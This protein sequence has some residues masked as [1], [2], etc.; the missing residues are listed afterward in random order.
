MENSSQKEPWEVAVEEAIAAGETIQVCTEDEN[1]NV[2]WCL[3]EPEKRLCT[4]MDE[5]VPGV[6][7]FPPDAL[8]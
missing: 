2:F 1:G 6:R 4:E 8:S 7:A 3:I 5:P